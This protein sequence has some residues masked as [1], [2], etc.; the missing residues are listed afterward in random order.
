MKK[1]LLM[2]IMVAI[3]PFMQAQTWSGH[4]FEDFTVGMGVAEQHEDF[5]VW[6]FA[7]VTDAIVVDSVSVSGSN[8]FIIDSPNDDIVWLLGNQDKATFE[9]SFKIMIEPGFGGYFNLQKDT[10]PG[11]QWGGDVFFGSDSTG[12]FSH[13]GLD[14][15]V[16][17]DYMPGEW[18][19][20]DIVVSLQLELAFLFINRGLVSSWTYS[21]DGTTGDPGLNVLGGVM[22]VDCDGDDVML[23]RENNSHNSSREKI[24][25]SP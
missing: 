17:F 3:C 14:N 20:V 9:I 23:F 5:I 4:N 16:E 10:V 7:G 21:Q 1:L 19:Q 25:A 13:G 11:T 2:A 18:T 8:S 12:Y 15:D 24:S 6:P 22:I